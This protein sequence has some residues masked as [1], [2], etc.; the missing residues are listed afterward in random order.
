[1]QGHFLHKLPFPFPLKV[2]IN[3]ESECYI[4]TYIKNAWKYPGHKGNFI[5]LTCNL[6]S[7]KIDI[8]ERGRWPKGFLCLNRLSAS[9]IHM[10]HKNIAF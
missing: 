3:V 2:T 5:K 4:L 9:G 10:H 1:M 6:D 7:F 8:K